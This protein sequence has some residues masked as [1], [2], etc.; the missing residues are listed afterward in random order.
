MDDGQA[1]YFVYVLGL[2]ARLIEI[3]RAEEF[4]A[5]FT[6]PFCQKRVN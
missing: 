5:S 3:I 2:A 4:D 1:K 6:K